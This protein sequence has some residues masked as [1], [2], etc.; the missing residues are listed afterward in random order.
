MAKI[1]RRKF[2]KRAAL[3]GAGLAA[4][5]LAPVEKTER[6]LAPYVKSS[7]IANKVIVLGMDGMDPNVL[8]RFVEEGAMPTFKKFMETGSSCNLATTIPPQS[9]VAWSSF[10][11]GTNPG[12]HGIYDFIHRDPKAFV[13]YLSTSRSFGAESSLKLGK[14]A[15]PLAAGRVELMRKGPVLWQILEEHGIPSSVFQIPANFPV[16]SGSSRVVSGMGTPDLLG[17]Y[18]TC[19]YITN[20]DVPGKDEM[21]S[22][23]V[24]NVSLQGHAATVRLG[25]PPN[26]FSS[27]A[28]ATGVDIEIQRDPRESTARITVDGHEIFLSKGEWS[29]WIPLRFNFLSMFAGVSGMVRFLLKE[30]HPYFRLYV[31]PV[32]VDPMDP[33]LP[34]ASPEGYSRELAEAVGRFYTQ[35]LPADTKALSNGILDDDEYLSQAKIVLEEN[36]RGF[37]YQIERFNEGMFFYYFSS[38]DQNQ[39]MLWRNMDPSHPLFDAHASPNV[40]GAIRHLYQSMDGVLKRALEKADNYTT[41]MLLSDHGFAPFYREFHL[42]TWLLDNGYISLH[43]P[44]D[45]SGDFFHNVNWDETKAF[46]LG[47]NGLYL[48]LRD[49]EANGVLSPREAMRVKT[50]LVHKLQ[51]VVDP[52]TGRRIVNTAFEAE[53]VYSGPYLDVAPD[54]VLGFDREYRTSD[55]S[56]LGKFTTDYVTDRTDKWAADHCMDPAVVPGVLLSNKRCAA[57]APG[58]WDMAPTI[59]KAFGI[60]TP[61]EMDGKAVLDM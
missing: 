60:E 3:A 15:V 34:I 33:S 43:D 37:E 18:G 39:H 42:N 45:R 23:R 21:S 44:E 48:N 52:K 40:K 6:L 31:T 57:T 1:D 4:S 11:T 2:L 16:A 53:K 38:L 59:L 22:V 8:K 46:G 32:N 7:K 51:E 28:E 17:T 41:V 5:G 56:V 25:G 24:I 10:I 12:G 58:I 35:G 26:P 14:W 9:P 47:I 19:T 13:P 50:E 61:K 54:M 55:T 20:A 36:I 30:V 29:E 49:R 27:T